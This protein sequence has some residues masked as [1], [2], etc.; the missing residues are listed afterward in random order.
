MLDHL[1]Q[2]LKGAPLWQKILLMVLLGVLF[3]YFVIGGSVTFMDKKLM[4]L[5]KKR[6]VLFRDVQVVRYL[7]NDREII[8]QNYQQVKY[9]IAKKIENEK[10]FE[11]RFSAL[12]RQHSDN[13]FFY[14]YNNT[15]GEDYN[16]IEKKYLQIKVRIT[17]KN[18]KVLLQQIER[19]NCLVIAKVDYDKNILDLELEYFVNNGIVVKQAPLPIVKT[20]KKSNPAAV[21]K[22]TRS[23]TLSPKILLQGFYVNDKEPK[24][25]IN[26]IVYKA[27]DKCGLYTIIEI[28]PEKKYVRLRYG[29]KTLIVRKK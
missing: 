2:E 28:Y 20:V 11:N 14:E 5:D 9:N 25:I 24:A 6:D 3:F 27:G 21:N 13:I 10:N 1:L 26:D 16:G 22:K 18:F 4:A 8:E 12:L 23:V 15:K 7:L 19:F 17:E 29:Q